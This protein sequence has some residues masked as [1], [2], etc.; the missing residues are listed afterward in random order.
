MT[1]ERVGSLYEATF[2]ATAAFNLLNGHIEGAVLCEF[3]RYEDMWGNARVRSGDT[4]A[5]VQSSV[6][7]TGEG[8]TYKKTT[9]IIAR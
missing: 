9:E 7:Y 6:T 2:N 3:L 1:F 8:Q 5:E 4:S